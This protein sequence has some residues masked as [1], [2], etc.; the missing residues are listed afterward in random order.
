MA[1]CTLGPDERP[2]RR[3]PRRRARPVRAGAGGRRRAGRVGRRRRQDRASGTGRSRPGPGRLGHQTGDGR[4]LLHVGG[5][6]QGQAVGRRRRR[7]S[8][9]AG[10]APVD[11]GG[12]RRVPHQLPAGGPAQARHRRRRRHRPQPDHHLRPGQ[13]PGAQ[14]RG[15]RGGRLR[16]RRLLEPL[17]LRG[18]APASAPRPCPS[19]APS[20]SPCPPPASATCRPACTWPAASSP[21]CGAGNAPAGE[22]WSTPPCWPR[23]SGPCR[24][25]WPERCRPAWRNCRSGPGPR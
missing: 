14:G 6:Q 4:L 13:R 10:A 24:A 5:L 3:H 11:A 7:P 18:T 25:A 16:R 9:R 8:R 21:P 19:A 17:P 23:G 12:R 22:R 20:R 2:P 1:S 15:G